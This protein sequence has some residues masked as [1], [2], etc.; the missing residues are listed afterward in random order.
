MRHLLLVILVLAPTLFLWAEEPEPYAVYDS[1]FLE[2]VDVYGDYNKYQAGAKIESLSTEQI[3]SAQEGGIEQLLMRFT[4]IYVKTNAGG[5][6]TIRIRGTAPDHTNIMFG[7]ININSLTLGHSDLS[8]I[9]SFLFEKMEIQY[10]SSSAINGSGAIGGAI[11]LGQKNH[12]T[13]GVKVNAKYSLGSFGE[14]LYG[15]KVYFGN[16]KWESVTKLIKYKTDNDFPYTISTGFDK[17]KEY[18][19]TGAAV[20]N[21]GVIQEFNYLFDPNEYFKSMLWYEDSW[22]QIQP[23]MNGQE[24]IV[25]VLQDNNLRFWSEYKNENNPVKYAFAAGY[26]HDKELYN[27]AP[28]Q[29]IQTDR[30][31]AEGSLKHAL[32]KKIEY[33]AGVKYKFMIPN[34]YSYSDSINL[35]EH[36]ADFYL[37][38]SYQPISRLKTTINLRQQLITNYHAPFTPALGIEYQWTKKK[39]NELTSTFNISRNYRVPTFN[40]RHWPTVSNLL[41]TPGLQPENGFTAETGVAYQHKRSKLSSEIKVN[42]FYMNIQKW[43]EWRNNNGS[44]PVNIESVISK[45]VELHGNAIL[46]TGEITSTLSANYTYNPSTKIEEGKPDQQLIYV[47]KN[48][49]N[50][51]YILQYDKFSFLI[52]GNYTGERYYYYIGEESQIRRSLPT[53]FITNCALNYKFNIKEQRFKA[54]FAANNIFNVS[55][56]NQRFYAMPGINFKASLTANINITNK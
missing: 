27:N 39:K 13:N 10:G 42:L 46:E 4:P 25:T 32:T 56:Q 45:G 23:Q 16:G 28:G 24:E 54:S 6:A 17:G 8:N 33:K 31:I 35:N 52:D 49:F 14:R 41:G 29:K 47:P 15:A 3:E 38:C 2:D 19:Q 36:N 18:I 22:H 43:I 5:L 50:A 40:D 55:Y 7:G 48:M 20:D 26:V 51:N 21:K 30:L 53:Y 11:Y 34:V 1:I 37:T 44:V 12:W 9:S